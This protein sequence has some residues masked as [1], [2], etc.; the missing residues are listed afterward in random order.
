MKKLA[1]ELGIPCSQMKMTSNDDTKW[2]MMAWTNNS[3]YDSNRGS[4]DYSEIDEEIINQ[5]S[6]MAREWWP[7]T[8]SVLRK[9]RKWTMILKA[10]RYE[11]KKCSWRKYQRNDEANE[12]KMKIYSIR[13]RMTNQRCQWDS[14][15][16]TT[17]K[18]EGRRNSDDHADINDM[19]EN[20]NYSRNE[21]KLIIIMK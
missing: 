10:N 19:K 21:G 15:E 7:M 12:E 14:E 1:S 20:D 11:R 3:K 5:C 13:E 16:V 17:Q 6:N 8:I 18:A 4:S 9:W 2:R